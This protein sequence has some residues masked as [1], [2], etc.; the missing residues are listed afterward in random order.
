MPHSECS[1]AVAQEN[2]HCAANLGGGQIKLAVAIEIRGD[3]L[4]VASRGRKIAAIERNGGCGGAYRE[5]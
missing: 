4:D 2:S 3:N 1:I 5:E